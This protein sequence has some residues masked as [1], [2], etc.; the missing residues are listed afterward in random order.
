MESSQIFQVGELVAITEFIPGRRAFIK[1]E[2]GFVSTCG[3]GYNAKLASFVSALA[4]INHGDVKLTGIVSDSNNAF[5]AYKIEIKS[6]ELPYLDFM[7]LTSEFAIDIAPE[8]IMNAPYSEG[9]IESEI[10]AM[11][12]LSIAR[13][14]A[15]IV[16]RSMTETDK[17]EFHFNMD[18]PA[19]RKEEINEE[20][21]D[22]KEVGGKE[23]NF[24]E[25]ADEYYE[26][27]R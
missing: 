21:T 6:R 5:Y 13:P 25:A 27:L 26:S 10:S 7:L 2:N 24:I 17:K 18:N 19:C 14:R 22:S 1:S 9:L 4:N 23:E 16:V 11:S 8:F 20:S 15:G 12:F 3:F